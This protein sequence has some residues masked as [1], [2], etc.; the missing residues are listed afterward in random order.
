MKT[1]YISMLLLATCFSSQAFAGNE[2]RVGSAGATELL[3]N[4]WSRSLGMASA[5]V[6]TVSGLEGAFVNV[7]GLAMLNKMEL[8]GARTNLYGK[9]GVKVNALG[10]GTKIGESSVLALTYT[11][12]NFGDIPVTTVDNPEGLGTTFS[13]RYTILGI[14]Y[15][16]TF[17]NSIY[18]GFQLKVINESIAN[19]KSGGVAF[20]A[21]IKY[22]TGEKDQIKFGINLKNVGPPMSYSGDGFAVT[23]NFA[24]V[25]PVNDF[26][27]TTEIRSAKFELPSQVNISFGYDFLFAETGKL[28]A[29]GCY[30][31]NSFS[32]DNY[33]LGL[34]YLHTLKKAQFG[35]R[36]GYN[37]EKGIFTSDT[38]TTA[39]TGPSFGAHVDFGKDTKSGSLIGIDYAFQ[40]VSYLSSTHTIGLRITLK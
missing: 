37:Y 12:F 26:Q 19:A 28:T 31:S 7:G 5:N 10:F 8:I 14:A 21:G 39:F 22:V 15:A 20:D 23:S 25:T 18:G 1:K 38:R 33:R 4:P 40:P 24:A 34:E 29:V 6:A 3:L 2:D 13:P 35:L 11:G 32:K 9:N 36:A 17:S 30:T 16:H 27:S